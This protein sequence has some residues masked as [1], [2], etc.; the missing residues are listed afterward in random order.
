MHGCNKEVAKLAKYYSINK[1]LAKLAEQIMRFI[2]MSCQKVICNKWGT[3]YILLLINK[4]S[5]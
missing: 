5:G 2:V 1:R 4:E 3:G